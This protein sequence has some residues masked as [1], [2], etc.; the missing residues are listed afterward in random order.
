MAQ[1]KSLLVNGTSR[2]LNTIYATDLSVSGT[3]SFASLDVSGNIVANGTLNIGSSTAANA[4]IYLNGKKAIAGT[5]G[6]LRINDTKAFGSGIYFGQNIIRT[7][8]SIQLGASGASVNMTTSGAT[9][10]IPIYMN[11]TTYKWTTDGKIVVND[12]NAATATLGNASITNGEV[13]DFHVNGTLKTFK[14]DIQHIANLGGN[15]LVTPSFTYSQPTAQVT[16]VTGQ[17]TYNLQISLTDSNTITTEIGGIAWTANSKIKAAGKING[18][19]IGTCDG[20]IS[21]ITTSSNTMIIRIL[22]DDD[23]D[24]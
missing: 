6:W 17:S 23:V 2:F 24:I 21:S 4:I 19:D 8:T 18:I 12:V 11:G 22:V 20:T 14:H 1:L 15:F 10:K 9:F 5:D 7:D 13:Q 3:T 16:R